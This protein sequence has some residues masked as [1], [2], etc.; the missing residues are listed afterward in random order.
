[1]DASV[2]TSERRRARRSWLRARKPGRP[3]IA[4]VEVL[5]ERLLL[6]GRMVAAMTTA[7][8]SLTAAQIQTAPQNATVVS[9]V[10]V[11]TGD[12]SLAPSGPG[13]VFVD[14]SSAPHATAAA[15]DALPSIADFAV[16]GTLD[17]GGPPQVF[18]L[19]LNAETTTL[20]L[21]FSWTT[22]PVFG[23]LM[24]LD[25]S[26]H[27]L[28]G[29]RL[30]A[31]TETIEI[32]FSQ[33]QGTSLYLVMAA[34]ASNQANPSASF[35]LR[36]VNNSQALEATTFG[37]DASAPRT[38]I[39]DS[40]AGTNQPGSNLLLNSATITPPPSYAASTTPPPSSP[41]SGTV[42]TPPAS[43]PNPP[44]GSTLSPQSTLSLPLASPAPVGGVFAMGTSNRAGDEIC[45]VVTDVN[46]LDL[47]VATVLN[48]LVAAS[49][50]EGPLSVWGLAAEGWPRMSAA[51]REANGSSVRGSG[52]DGEWSKGIVAP[53]MNDVPA[54]TAYPLP[55]ALRPW[56]VPGWG[57]FRPHHA[58][59]DERR[60]PERAALPLAGAE[61]LAAT[62]AASQDPLPTRVAERAPEPQRPRRSSRTELVLASVYGS[63]CVVLG[64]SAPG[65][66]SSLRR[67]RG[68]QRRVLA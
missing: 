47:P 33:A 64:L 58:G 42:N 13:T 29:Q 67:R 32:D 53:E 27:V 40:A 6:T 57:R 41:T 30:A 68:R 45:S 18:R 59:D 55:F 25:N 52:P 22:P 36:V 17:A 54:K 4:R 10:N 3:L 38:S 28:T 15:A 11:L 66:Q 61:Q 51:E 1:M 16:S 12:E 31:D 23:T 50:A 24:V 43:N 44:S 65:L 14:D 56:N 9:A 20:D 2:S 60:T 39:V 5:E 37:I 8:E 26:G 63:A 48:E 21:V 49:N 46:L 35:V 62:L 7:N 34:P 19:P